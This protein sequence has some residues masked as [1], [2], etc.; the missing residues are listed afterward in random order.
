MLTISISHVPFKLLQCGYPA[1]PAEAFHTK[2][3]HNFWVTKSNGHFSLSMLPAFPTAL[4][5]VDHFFLDTLCL[6]FFEIYLAWYL[7]YF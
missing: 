2:I 6:G 4:S 7:S 3:I 5:T 1:V